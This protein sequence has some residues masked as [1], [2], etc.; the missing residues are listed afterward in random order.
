MSATIRF[1]ASDN[2]RVY[3]RGRF[4]LILSTA[5]G[6]LADP[7]KIPTLMRDVS[8]ICADEFHDAWP[9]RYPP[10]EGLPLQHLDFSDYPLGEQ[11]EVLGA[12]RRAAD[13]FRNGDVPQCIVY[14][15]EN[16]PSIADSA[17]EIATLLENGMIESTPF[18]RK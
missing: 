17:D 12:L 11:E 5:V 4:A 15:R 13:A 7:A 8:A 16:G 9:D 2:G 1:P 14:T 3:P 18:V 10:D 6:A